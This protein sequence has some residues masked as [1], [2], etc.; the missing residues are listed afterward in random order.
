MPQH[1]RVYRWNKAGAI[2]SQYE[3]WP[4]AADKIGNDAFIIDPLDEGNGYE[5]GIVSAYVTGAFERWSA[6]AV[7]MWTSATATSAPS[8]SGSART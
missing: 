5:N 4:N 2:E 3:I 1:P 6:W 8:S 7:W